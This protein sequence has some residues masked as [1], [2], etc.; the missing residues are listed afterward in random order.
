MSNS[1]SNKLAIVK[2][3]INKYKFEEA[4]RQVKDIEEGRNLTPEEA[5]RTQ[6]YKATIHSRL[7]Q[8]D[9]AVKIAEELYQNSQ[10]MKMSLFTLDAL[11]CKGF[12]FYVQGRNEEFLRI[13][14]QHEKLFNSIPREESREYQ[15]REAFYLLRKGSREYNIGDL[16]LALDYYEKSL[17]VFEEIDPN[18]SVIHVILT[19]IA[20]AYLVKGELNLALEYTEKTLSL[21]PE[22]ENFYLLNIKANLLLNLG[23]LYWQKGELDSAL[24]YLIRELEIA[25]EIKYPLKPYIHIIC[26][27]VAKNDLAQAHY[28]LEECKLNTEKPESDLRY[29]GAHALIL[30]T[31]PRLRDHFEAATILKRVIE[32]FCRDLSNLLDMFLC[33]VLLVSLSDLYSRTL[34][35][36]FD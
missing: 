33:G 20:F 29:Q 34:E 26:V 15:E 11:Y 4:L 7:G 21:L 32:E 14:E 31:S 36:S 9:V 23:V 25:K 17:Q 8:F 24:E 22:G 5:L 2:N 16:N 12:I 19:G 27:L 13:I 18:S 3:L 10:E 6:A 35:I 28:Y 30:K 1:E